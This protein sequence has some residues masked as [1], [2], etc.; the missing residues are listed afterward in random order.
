M[1]QP[2]IIRRVRSWLAERLFVLAGRLDETYDVWLDD[3]PRRFDI[4]RYLLEGDGIDPGLAT[5][6]PN[7]HYTHDQVTW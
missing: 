1:N 2:S 4:E 7:D 3:A 5:K 6:V